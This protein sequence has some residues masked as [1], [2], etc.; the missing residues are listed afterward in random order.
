[1]QAVDAIPADGWAKPTL[2]EGWTAAHVV[3][4]VTTGDQL[5]Q[6]LL[7]DALAKDR[8]GLDLPVDRADRQRRFEALSTWEPARLKEAAHTASEH[9]VAAIGEAIE[10]AP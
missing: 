9:T 10:T 4:H 6:G 8:T 5:F 2:C 7:L 1:M 3:A